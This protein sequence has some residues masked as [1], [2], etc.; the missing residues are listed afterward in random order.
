M[1]KEQKGFTL[2]EVMIGLAILAGVVFTLLGAF[3][4]HLGVAADRRD[5]VMA[6]VLGKTKAEEASLSG[7]P[8]KTAGSFDGTNVGFSWKMTSGKTDVPG[9]ERLEVKVMWNGE[10]SFSL[11]SFI[12]D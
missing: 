11:S 1:F 9:L 8:D 7:L 5:L 6:A 3:N 4:Y 10:R 2:L 12:R